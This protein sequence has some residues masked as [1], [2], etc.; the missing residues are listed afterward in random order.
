MF[1]RDLQNSMLKREQ[2]SSFNTYI[3]LIKKQ[4][5][6]ESSVQT[7]GKSKIEQFFNLGFA[8]TVKLIDFQGLY[9][10]P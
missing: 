7:C 8:A 10:L 9:I 4:E 1:L 2:S 6:A 5:K 3:T